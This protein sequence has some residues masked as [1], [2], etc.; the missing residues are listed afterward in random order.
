MKH[1]TKEQ[2]IQ[3]WRQAERNNRRLAQKI[4]SLE[5]SV[6]FLDALRKK[7][8]QDRNDLKRDISGYADKFVLMRSEIEQLRR[9]SKT[10]IEQENA[11]LKRKLERLS[12]E[13]ESISLRAV[14]DCATALTC[15]FYRP[16]L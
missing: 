10:A 2:A 5:G 12:G 15:K 16:S 8:I 1:T 14:S 4:S 13:R 6:L 11:M 7:I 9:R 3:M